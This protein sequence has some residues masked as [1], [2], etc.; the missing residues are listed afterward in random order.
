MNS[1]YSSSKFFCDTNLFSNSDLLE[2]ILD[3]HSYTARI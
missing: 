1:E 3:S 2:V